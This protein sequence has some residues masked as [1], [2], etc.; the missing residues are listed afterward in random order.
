MARTHLSPNFKLEFDSCMT[1][2]H[3]YMK[4]WRPVEGQTLYCD[5]DKRLEAKVHDPTSVGIYTETKQLVGHVPREFSHALHKFIGKNR[6]V[7]HVHVT[8]EKYN[9]GKKG[10]V[11]PCRYSCASFLWSNKNDLSKELVKSDVTTTSKKII[12][13]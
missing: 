3:V 12:F 9:A 2:F 1:G 4:K 6:N 7:V 8:G 13:N 10:L 5:V 11:L